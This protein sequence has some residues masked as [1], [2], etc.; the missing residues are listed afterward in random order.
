L[1][2]WID[3]NVWA[4]FKKYRQNGKGKFTPYAQKLAVIKLEKLKAEGHNPDEVIKQT[5]ENGWSGLFPTQKSEKSEDITAWRKE[6]L[7]RQ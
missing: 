3:K 1:P 7:A 4:E 5:I 2:E 6:I